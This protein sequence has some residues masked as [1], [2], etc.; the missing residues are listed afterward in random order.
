MV[1]RIFKNLFK[2]FILPIIA[3]VVASG[4]GFR[5][6]VLDFIVIIAILVSFIFLLTL[7][8]PTEPSK[9]KYNKNTSLYYWMDDLTDY[10]EFLVYS[11]KNYNIKYSTIDNLTNIK[12]MI[13]KMTNKEKSKLKLYRIFYEQQLK[14]NG[15]SL[16]LK[17]ILVSLIPIFTLV[18][19]DYFFNINTFSIQIM[20]VFF[21]FIT[22]AAIGMKLGSNQKRI[23]IIIGIID[24]C[25]EEIEEENRKMKHKHK[26]KQREDGEEF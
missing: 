5:G 22:I 25:I 7:L 9:N 17:T 19:R 11:L 1:S 6:L 24:L 16:Y 2:G 12:N 20:L 23:G 18:F 21:L 14:E 13:F 15:E 8:F 10:D 26:H 3:V 4:I